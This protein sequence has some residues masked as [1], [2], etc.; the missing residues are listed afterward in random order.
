MEV[1][2]N[3]RH[4]AQNDISRAK[5]ELGKHATEIVLTP[6]SD[7]SGYLI[8]GQWNL[9][10]NEQFQNVVKECGVGMVPGGGVEPPRGVNLGGF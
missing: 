6:Q 9:V 3:I 5:V 2:P 4:L 8:E 10:W 7:G 1:I